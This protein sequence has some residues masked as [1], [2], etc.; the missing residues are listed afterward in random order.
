MRLP[1]RLMQRIGMIFAISILAAVIPATAGL[2]ASSHAG[3]AATATEARSA[4]HSLLTGEHRLSDNSLAKA[5]ATPDGAYNNCFSSLYCSFNSTNGN[6]ECL[7]GGL[8]NPVNW[9]SACRNHD[10]S[11]ANIVSGLVR[12]YYSPNE[13]GAWACIPNGWYSNNL[14]KSAYTFDNGSGDAGYG[15]EIWENIASSAGGGLNGGKCSNPL[16]EDG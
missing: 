10:E 14:N 13:K 3:R 12:V 11:F 9:P 15:Q 2:A 16:P 4:D 8:V 1:T 7:E 6:N 5:T